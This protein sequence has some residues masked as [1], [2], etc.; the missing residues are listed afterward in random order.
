MFSCSFD[1]KTKGEDTMK[2]YVKKFLFI[3][4]LTLLIG[5]TVLGVAFGGAVLGYWGGVDEGRLDYLLSSMSSLRINSKLVYLDPDTGEEVVLQEL[6]EKENRIWAD[7]EEV[8]EHLQKAFISIEDERFYDHRGFDFWR[9]AKATITWLGDKITG[10]NGVATLGGSTITQQTIKNVMGENEQTPARKILEIS[11]AV[12]LEKKMSK[13]QILECYL[14][15][16]Y[17]SEGCNGVQTAAQLYF[18]KDVSQ[19]TLAESAS[20][21]GITKFPSLYNPFDNPEK[22]KER[23]EIVLGKMRELGHIS[24]EEYEQAVAEKLMFADPAAKEKENQPATMSYFVDR[25]IME[26]LEDLRESGYSENVASKIL[27]SGGVTVYTTYVPKVQKAVEDYYKNA[28]RF[29]GD[30]QSAMAIVD[31]TNGNVVGIAGGIGEKP[32]SL[33]LNRASSPRQPGSTFKP[34]GVYAP[35]LDRGLITAGSTFD[36]KQKAYEGW[37]PRNY[38]YQYRGKVDVRQAVRTSLNTTPVEILSQ[39]GARESFDFL[40]NKLGYTTLVEERPTDNGFL[41]D[42]GYP[43]LALGGLTDGATA[44][45]MAAAYAAFANNGIYNAPHTYTEVKDKDGN[46]IL[47]GGKAPVEAMKPSTAYI[48][49]QLLR[50]VVTSGTGRG[51]G[52]GV[53]TAGKTGTT[54]QN[55]DR[56][57]VGYTPYY[58]AAVW[59]GYDMPKEIYASGNPCIPVFQTIMS[60]IHT[61][62]KEQRSI[63]RPKDVV[64]VRYCTWTGKRARAG[65]PSDTYYFSKDNIPGNCNSNHAGYVPPEA[66]ATASAEPTASASATPDGTAVAPGGTP[67]GGTT[68]GGTTTGGTTSGGTT[69]GG[70]TTGGTT[71]GGTTSGGTTSGGTTSGGTTSG[72]G[73]TAGGEA[74]SGGVPITE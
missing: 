53:F 46:V 29:Y 22:N 52:I 5:G 68:T 44:I 43:Q 9:T 14:N 28:N 47:K 41:T 3:F 26:V 40:R 35:A 27:Y 62:L 48:M 39:M 10:K 18:D 59:Y 17:L 7:L 64:E 12:A 61:G 8:P 36:D 23:Q 49:S 51:A 30:A 33:T 71:S 72:T 42:I 58:S 54:S 34:V 66:S 65:C 69:T 31:V 4:V 25:V 55:F 11:E 37:V 6:S 63:V 45:E 13:E 1:Q 2:R 19:L 60:Q 56:W 57:F 15:C 70:T 74:A 32:G 16:I 73:T 20:L 24:Q 38:D 67:S 21:A 50:E